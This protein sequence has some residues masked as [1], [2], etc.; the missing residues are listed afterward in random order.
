M[1]NWKQTHEGMMIFAPGPLKYWNRYK[2][3]VEAEKK[4]EKNANA[5][6]YNSTKS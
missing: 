6:K 2:T 3:K 4:T 1:E 5:N